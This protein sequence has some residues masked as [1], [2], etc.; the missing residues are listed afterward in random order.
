MMPLQID[1]D[2]IVDLLRLVNVI[3]AL[4][5][6]YPAFFVA[7]KLYQEKKR[8]NGKHHLFTRL[9]SM[10]LYLLIIVTSLNMLI[11]FLFFVNFNFDNIFGHDISLIVFNIRNMFIN[12]TLSFISWVLYFVYKRG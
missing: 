10:T 8:G 4:V 5:S 9:L 12:L 3:I 6:L 2:Y 1:K 11:S 7:N